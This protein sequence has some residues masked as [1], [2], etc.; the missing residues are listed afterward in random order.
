MR[1]LV[2]IAALLPLAACSP[3]GSG[4]SGEVTYYEDIRP[5]LSANCVR[6]H[7]EGSIAPFGLESYEEA[8]IVSERMRDATRDRIMP[9]YL[10]DAS[11][12]CNDYRDAARLTDEEIALID[13]WHTQGNPMGDPST[14][15][16]EVLPSPTLD[17]TVATIDLGAS[18]EPN[19]TVD[20]DYRCFVVDAPRGG[21]VTGYEVRPDNDAIVHHVIVYAPD[22]AAAG[23]GAVEADAADPGPGYTCYGGAGVNAAPV[24]L[25]APGGGATNFP[26]GTGVELDPTIPLVIQVHYNLQ[27]GEGL[28]RTEVDLEFADTASPAYIVPLAH[29]G[30]SLPPRMESVSS[31]YGY[32]LSAVGLRLPVRV[33]GTFP[34]MHERGTALRVERVLGD[35][36]EM[37]MTDV[38]RWDFQWQLAYWYDTPIQVQPDETLRITCTWNTMD[39]SDTIT[40]GEGTEDEMCLNYFYVTL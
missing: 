38:P 21:F 24:V 25:W 22:D 34:H 10:V 20:D 30:F 27:A 33:H 23:R 4:P 1:S 15:P 3:N 5:I 31:T 13:A 7:Q 17:G 14:A 28:D 8:V 18:Y 36:T 39:A 12:D 40:W 26:R 16:P 35:G 2:A 6:C 19:V 29:L 9:P 37:C 11:G 32:S